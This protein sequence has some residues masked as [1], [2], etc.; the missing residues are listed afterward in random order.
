MQSL[1][2]GQLAPVL[3]LLLRRRPGDRPSAA[4]AQL[5]LEAVAAGKRIRQRRSR[6]AVLGLGAVALLG[7]VAVPVVAFSAATDAGTPGLGEPRTADPCELISASALERFGETTLETDYGNFNRCDVII[8]VASEPS[9]KATVWLEN[10]DQDG[11]PAGTMEH[12]GAIDVVRQL[13]L[14]RTCRRVISLPDRT[15]VVV[16]AKVDNGDSSN[17]CTVADTVT[18]TALDVLTAGAV[19]RRA[20]PFDAVSLGSTDACALLGAADFAPVPDL[21]NATPD[22]KFGNWGCRWDVPD[23]PAVS[24]RFNRHNSGIDAEDGTPIRIAGRAAAFRRDDERE[25]DVTVLHRPYTDPRGNR[26]T[27]LLIVEVAQASPVPDP[28]PAATQV[29]T[30]AA[31]RLPAVS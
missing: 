26:S 23:G 22:P 13:L 18:D 4:E 9:I 12:R 21:Q 25:C 16:T 11:L 24:V 15:D 20:L 6:R 19:P 27:E 28:C 7:L 8:K 3:R 5:Q 30:A 17:L 29:A 31:E 14:D 10:T 2:A 1:N